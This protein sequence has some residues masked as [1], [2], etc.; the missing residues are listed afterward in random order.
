[1]AASVQ[2]DDNQVVEAF[3]AFLL[4]KG[5]PRKISSALDALADYLKKAVATALTRAIKLKSETKHSNNGKQSL[6]QKLRF[7]KGV[8]APINSELSLITNMPFATGVSSTRFKLEN[9]IPDQKRDN[10]LSQTTADPS[11]Y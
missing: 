9:I 2:S 5:N 4:P 11:E 3:T 1:M 7:V 8:Q 10:K 6:H